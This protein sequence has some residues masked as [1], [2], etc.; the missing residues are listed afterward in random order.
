MQFLGHTFRALENLIWDMGKTK[1]TNQ[2]TLVQEYAM[3]TRKF[4][5][6]E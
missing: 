3:I 5:D 6:L 1:G 4:L 2:T